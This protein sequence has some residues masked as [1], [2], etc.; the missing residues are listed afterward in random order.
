MNEESSEPEHY[1]LLRSHA[2]VHDFVLCYA[3]R[4]ADVPHH[5]RVKGPWNGT[6]RGEV[7]KLKPEIRLVLAQARYVLVHCPDAVFNPEV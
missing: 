1:H 4:S 7:A 3:D 6:G 2:D 5:V